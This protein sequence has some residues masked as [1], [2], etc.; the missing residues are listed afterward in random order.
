MK[1]FT[2]IQPKHGDS[3]IHCGHLDAKNHHFFQ[4]QPG[5]L[6]FRRPDGTMGSAKWVVACE[7]CFQKAGGDAQKVEIRGDGTWQGNEPAV[8]KKED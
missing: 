2:K 4:V 3:M 6:M 5:P 1:N 7:A 8:T